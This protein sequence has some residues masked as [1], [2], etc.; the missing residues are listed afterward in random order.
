M[1]YLKSEQPHR[2]HQQDLTWMN[3]NINYIK[4]RLKRKHD[5]KLKI[6]TKSTHE[7]KNKNNRQTWN[8]AN[9]TR[10]VNNINNIE[11]TVV[12]R[13]N[14][15]F[16]QQQLNVLEK[17]LKFIPTPKTINL[18]DIIANTEKSLSLSPKLIKQTAILEIS[19]FVA[20]W[21]KPK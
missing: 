6:L 21:K 3:K 10:Y 11:S 4:R 2:N 18:V 5:E 17:G 7:N 8:D 20:T 9:A 14:K 19:T 16:S 1:R 15:T 12:N 13:S